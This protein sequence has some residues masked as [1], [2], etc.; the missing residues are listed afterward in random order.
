MQGGTLTF[1]IYSSHLASLLLLLQLVLQLSNGFAG[2]A[3][4]LL[5]PCLMLQ[6]SFCSSCLTRLLLLLELA[7]QL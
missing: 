2:F 7:L 6:I 5:Q 1:S 3:V 4:G